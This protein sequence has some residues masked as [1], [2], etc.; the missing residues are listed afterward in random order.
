M[1]DLP[2]SERVCGIS[3]G[4]DNARRCSEGVEE[5]CTPP[6]PELVSV[7]GHWGQAICILIQITKGAAGCNFTRREQPG[8]VPA[9]FLEPHS[10]TR[11]SVHSSI[12]P[13]EAP[14]PVCCRSQDDLAG[15]LIASGL[16]YATYIRC[17]ASVQGAI[18]PV[19]GGAWGAGARFAL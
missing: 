2:V 6:F 4:R 14:G 1:S 12:L 10:T 3:T 5:A 7:K 8:C 17:H 19:A 16:L 9:P 18:L 11:C 15:N 13:L